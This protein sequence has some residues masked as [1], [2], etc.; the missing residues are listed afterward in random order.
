MINGITTSRRRRCPTCRSSML[1]RRTPRTMNQVGITAA[2]S[3]AN[4][5]QA[6]PA[7]P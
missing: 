2:N 3:A 7:Q 1:P 4:A 5:A 6:S